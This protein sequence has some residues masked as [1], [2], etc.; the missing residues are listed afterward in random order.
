ML[1][2]IRVEFTESKTESQGCVNVILKNQTLLGILVNSPSMKDIPNHDINIPSTDRSDPHGSEERI[3][4]A[5]FKRRSQV[6]FTL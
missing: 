3:L 6:F 5:S 2:L 1:S 4:L